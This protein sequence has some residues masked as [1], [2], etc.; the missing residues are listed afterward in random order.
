MTLDW[1]FCLYLKVHLS[2]GKEMFKVSDSDMGVTYDGRNLITIDWTIDWTYGCSLTIPITSRISSA[3]MPCV[4]IVGLVFF[5]SL[6]FLLRITLNIKSE[7]RF[8][9]S[10]ENI[11]KKV[12]LWHK[13]RNRPV[14]D[15][16]KFHEAADWL[17]V[18]VWFYRTFFWFVLTNSS[19]DLALPCGLFVFGCIPLYS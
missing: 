15:P 18:F 10:N 5:L 14:S 13:I 7:M 2:H 8:F 1:R 12:G 9:K 6:C 11:H 17:E 4:L 19:F 16:Q 3:M